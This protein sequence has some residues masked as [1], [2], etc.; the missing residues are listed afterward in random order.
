MN[1][2]NPKYILRN[3]LAQRAIELAQ[4]DDFSEVQ[5]LQTI[6]SKPFEEQPEYEAY[7]S[8]PPKHLETVE[9]SCSS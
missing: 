4:K 7:A 9:V 1:Q 8:P 3:Y 5:K 2:A 6:L